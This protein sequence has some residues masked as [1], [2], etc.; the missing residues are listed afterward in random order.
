MM[1]NHHADVVFYIKLIQISIEICHYQSSNWFN[2][3]VKLHPFSNNLDENRPKYVIFDKQQCSIWDDGQQLQWL[4]Y[5]NLSSA[6]MAEP[7]NLEIKEYA[8]LLGSK[9]ISPSISFLSRKDIEL[10]G[11]LIWKERMG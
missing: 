9:Q 2:N 7:A 6:K 5:S 11:M 8:S 4:Y 1:M 3:S 10:W